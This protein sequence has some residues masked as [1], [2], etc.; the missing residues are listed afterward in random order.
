MLGDDVAEVARA[1]FGGGPGAEGL[2]DR[3]H[4]VVNRLGETDDGERIVVLREEGGEVGGG[5]VGVVAAD[6]VENI[7]TIFN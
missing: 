1:L 4:V 6:G 7:D 5:G 2:A 3:I